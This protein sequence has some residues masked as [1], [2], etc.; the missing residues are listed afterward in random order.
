MSRK[1]MNERKINT[2]LLSLINRS[3]SRKSQISVMDILVSPRCES[4]I[5]EIYINLSI[6]S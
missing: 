1:E 3:K 5:T 2:L 6:H 4:W